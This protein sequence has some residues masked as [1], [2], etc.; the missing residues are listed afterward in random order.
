MLAWMVSWIDD[1]S[2]SGKGPEFVAGLGQ[3]DD[4][5][6]GHEQADGAVK[7]PAVGVLDESVDRAD[8]TDR[9]EQ[10]VGAF[11]P[12]LEVLMDVARQADQATSSAKT[13]V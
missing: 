12:D 6:A 9:A 11:A 8:P 1:G 10:D 3:Q 13:R 4:L 7:L 5:A 2:G